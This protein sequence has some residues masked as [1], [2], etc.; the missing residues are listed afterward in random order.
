MVNVYTF[1]VYSQASLLCVS[2]VAPA[3]CSVYPLPERL[4]TRSAPQPER[5]RVKQYNP[6]YLMSPL[7]YIGKNRVCRGQR[8]ESIL[9]LTGSILDIMVPKICLIQ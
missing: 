9:D 6:N 1:C 4:H 2:K 8:F 3:S 5:T 7:L